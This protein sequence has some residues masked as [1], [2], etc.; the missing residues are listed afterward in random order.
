MDIR[1]QFSTSFL[2]WKMRVLWLSRLWCFNF[3]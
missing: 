1:L 3:F 2:D